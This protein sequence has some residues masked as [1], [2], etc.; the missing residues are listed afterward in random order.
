MGGRRR[1]LKNTPG[2]LIWLR[3]ARFNQ[4]RNRRGN[5]NLRLFAQ[6]LNGTGRAL[7]VGG[8]IQAAALLAI[9]KI[10]VDDLEGSVLQTAASLMSIERNEGENENGKGGEPQATDGRVEILGHLIESG[11]PIPAKGG[12][13]SAAAVILA[14]MSI[15]DSTV[16]PSEKQHSWSSTARC[17]G[18]KITVRAISETEC[19]IWRIE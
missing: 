1:R 15:G 6:F 7:E 18:M 10:K 17:C 9:A 19:R 5:I 4:T 14:G 8:P 3:W 12:K 16:I 2:F 11:I 13:K